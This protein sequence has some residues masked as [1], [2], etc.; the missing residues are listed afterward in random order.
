LYVAPHDPA[1]T[2]PVDALT[3]EVRNATDKPIEI[4]TFNGRTPCLDVRITGYRKLRTPPAF[5]GARREP[6]AL[7]PGKTWNCKV[8]DGYLIAYGRYGGGDSFEDGWVEFDPAGKM[9]ELSIMRGAGLRRLLNDLA[10]RKPA[11]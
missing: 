6:F 4:D 5:G 10:K 7:E 1:K 3:F 8:S 11:G 2:R 9:Y